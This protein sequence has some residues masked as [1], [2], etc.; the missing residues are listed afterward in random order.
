MIATAPDDANLQAALGDI[1]ANQNQW[2][3]A[4]RA[5]FDAYRLSQSAENAFNLA[6]SLDQIGKPVL[7]LPYYREALQKAAPSSAIDVN[8][9]EATLKLWQNKDVN[10]A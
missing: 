7:A 9:L 5:Y 4:Q 8:A 6:V 3:A 10:Y 1:Y 2:S